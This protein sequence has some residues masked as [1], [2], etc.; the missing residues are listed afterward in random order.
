MLAA[1]SAASRSNSAS[2]SRFFSPSVVRKSVQRER[3]LPAMCFMTMAIEFDSGP[4]VEKKC[5][6]GTCAI[7][8]SASRRYLRSSAI[9]PRRY[10]APATPAS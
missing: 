4:I 6:S 5:S 7:A 10:S 9:A 1:S 2:R 3:M 8:A